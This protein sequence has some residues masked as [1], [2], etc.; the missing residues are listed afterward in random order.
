MVFFFNNKHE[1]YLINVS[2][3]N[4]AMEDIYVS[5]SHSM[6]RHYSHLH[7]TIFIFNEVPIEAFYLYLFYKDN[8]YF[9][10]LQLRKR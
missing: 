9:V 5:T 3:K 8:L 2:L 4:V 7:V 1:I 10:F 6:S